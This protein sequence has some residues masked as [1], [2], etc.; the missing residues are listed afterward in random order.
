M[1][2]RNQIHF[3]LQKSYGQILGILNFYKKFIPNLAEISLALT[4]ILQ[5]KKLVSIQF[6][7]KLSSFDNLTFPDFGA[8]LSLAVDVLRFTMSAA[9]Q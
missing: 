9:L 8:V 6:G 1:P 2:E 7:K 4:N 5:R 3:W